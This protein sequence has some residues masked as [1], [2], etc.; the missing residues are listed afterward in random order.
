MQ[1][2]TILYIILIYEKK[3]IFCIKRIR[4]CTNMI[5]VCIYKSFVY[6]HLRSDCERDD[7]Y[8]AIH[9]LSW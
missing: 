2:S 5:I 7:I 6:M 3:N 1:L 9:Q 4:N 8:F